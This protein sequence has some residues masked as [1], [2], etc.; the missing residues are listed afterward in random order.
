[1]SASVKHPRGPHICEGSSMRLIGSVPRRPEGSA[2]LRSPPDDGAC[3]SDMGELVGQKLPPLAAARGRRR[4]PQTRCRRR[5][6]KPGRRSPRR[7]TP[8]PRRRGRA[9]RRGRQ[10]GARRRF[11]RRCPADVP[12]LSRTL[13]SRAL[14][15]WGPAV[16]RGLAPERVLVALRQEL[17]VP[18]HAHVPISPAHDA[19]GGPV[20]FRFL[21]VMDPA[22]GEIPAQPL[23]PQMVLQRL[24]A[25]C[26][27][28]AERRGPGMRV[29]VRGASGAAHGLLGW[30]IEHR[31]ALTPSLNTST[32]G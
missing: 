19:V 9:R 16:R 12:R 22:H 28:G 17:Q 29:V 13:P 6:R 18:P 32:K 4:R 31:R 24:V 2:V 3:L 23:G 5:P 1:M 25:D 14:R 20:R 26:D 30:N 15:I 11:G 7:S 10:S 8:P 21:R 27:R